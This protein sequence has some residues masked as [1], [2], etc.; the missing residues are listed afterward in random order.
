MHELRNQHVSIGEF[1]SK[2]ERAMLF[3]HGQGQKKRTITYSKAICWV[4]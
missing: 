3:V 4:S 2:E 1:F